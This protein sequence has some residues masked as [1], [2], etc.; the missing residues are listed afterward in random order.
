MLI[1]SVIVEILRV[2]RNLVRLALLT[3]LELH[4][5]LLSAEKQLALFVERKA[6]PRRATLEDKF[7]LVFLSR[8]HNWRDAIVIVSPRTFKS[9][10]DL[11]VLRKWRV[12]CQQ[13]SVGRPPVEN[14]TRDLIR[15]LAMENPLW[16]ARRIRDELLTKFGLAVARNTVQRYMP[17]RPPRTRPD[18]SP[19][20]RTFIRNH[21]RK[22]VAIDFAVAIAPSLSGRL[23]HFYILVVMELGSRRMLHAGVTEHPSA[24]WTSN[25]LRHAL[26]S[27]AGY[28]YLIHDNDSIFSND[29]DAA[30]ASLGIAPIRTP[31]RAPKANAHCERLIGTLR[32][33]CLDWII[34]LGERHL[35]AVVNEWRN[36]Y[37]RGRP[38]MALAGGVPD[39]PEDLPVAR[40]AHRHRL[41]EGSKIESTS[42]LGGLHHDYRFINDRAA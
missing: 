1:L 24:F 31:F 41:P 27:D 33:E 39:A 20:W 10:I 21:A 18:G 17:R 26:P 9:W 16:S 6:R 8:F 34:P 5:R 28:K 2:V 22:I 30:V 37:N 42:I 36:H 13:K 40:Q 38:H 11:Y 35:R 23:R 19:T 32:R 25:Q 29:V 12:I 14:E 3:D 4:A 15:R 7:A